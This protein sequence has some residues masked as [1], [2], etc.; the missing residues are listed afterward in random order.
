MTKKLQCE[1]S[2]KTNFGK[3]NEW[4]LTEIEKYGL[5]YV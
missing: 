1:L 3:D 5:I 4:L 2:N